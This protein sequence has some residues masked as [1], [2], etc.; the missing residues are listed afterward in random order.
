MQ[1]LIFEKSLLLTYCKG[2]D[3]C[4]P[5]LQEDSR[6]CGDMDKLKQAGERD[7]NVQREPKTEGLSSEGW[8]WARIAGSDAARSQ[9]EEENLLGPLI[10]CR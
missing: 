2:C 9:Q 1:V 8:N 3:R 4:S 7:D 6:R 10:N 5:E